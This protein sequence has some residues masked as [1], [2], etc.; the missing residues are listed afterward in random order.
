MC[1]LWNFAGQVDYFVIA[2]VIASQLTNHLLITSLLITA[3][4]TSA[5]W[6]GVNRVLI[7]DSS[8]G[9]FVGDV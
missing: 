6:A 8:G 7:S 3:N 9:D 4:T 2:C 5:Y 1:E